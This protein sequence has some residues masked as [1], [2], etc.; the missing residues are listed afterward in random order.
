MG[1]NIFN[2]LSV[3]AGSSSVKLSL[4]ANSDESQ[5]PKLLNAKSLEVHNNRP[6][7][8]SEISQWIEHISPEFSINAVGHRVVHG[9]P[10]HTQAALI[11][12]K[13][14]A[15]LRAF[16]N[17]DPEHLPIE[18]EIIEELRK[19]LPE[20]KQIACFDTAFFQDL[21]LQAKLLPLPRKFQSAGIQRYGFH[22]LS[23][24]YLQQEF[25]KIAGESAANG[26]VIFAHLG[27][28]ASLA[29]TKG[30]VPL[31][32]T[33]SFTPASGLV[34]SSRSGDIDP[35]LALFFNRQYGLSFEEFN[36]MVNF[37]SGMLGVSELSGS[38]RTLLE[39]EASNQKAAEAIELFVYSTRKAIGSMSAVLGG[40]DSMIFSGGIGEPSSIIRSRICE[41]L[42]YLG[43]KL[44]TS[45]NDQNATL[46]S[47][48]DSNVG[49]HVIPTDEASI[50][51]RQVLDI[52]D[53][54][55]EG[56][57]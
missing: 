19:L 32:T 8:A 56:E 37:D 36:H 28:G 50:V 6:S 55:S 17:F 2:I 49:V 4:Y 5:T 45:R 11:D 13:L 38:M 1:T 27:S 14:I 33:M 10:D 9:G 30:G 7:I 29:A 34:M 31:D 52:L 35:G 53:I 40:L 18:I 42:G 47:S 22:G 44:D 54:H 15:D 51:V 12:D 23:Y 20:A 25:G 26:R 24:T 48:H 57:D 16:S 3:N 43:I 41:N 21:P 39:N 46:I